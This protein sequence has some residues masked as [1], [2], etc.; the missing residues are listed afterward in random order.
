MHDVLSLL[1]TCLCMLCVYLCVLHGGKGMG[2]IS[3][4]VPLWNILYHCVTLR[5]IVYHICNQYCVSWP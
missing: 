4:H 5:S 1:P 3:V 2:F